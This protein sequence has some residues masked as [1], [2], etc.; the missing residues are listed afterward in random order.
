M[1]SSTIGDVHSSETADSCVCAGHSLMAGALDR[2]RA[3]TGNPPAHSPSGV[4]SRDHGT[5]GGGSGGNVA[6]GRLVASAPVHVAIPGSIAGNLDQQRHRAGRL[7]APQ[8]RQSRLV[9]GGQPT[10]LAGLRL[11]DRPSLQRDLKASSAMGDHPAAP[12]GSPPSTR[13]SANVAACFRLRSVR[14]F[15]GIDVLRWERRHASTVGSGP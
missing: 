13:S 8:R 4:R 3:A 15:L 7:R 6:T 11:R 14:L 9:L 5:D 12:G 2:R 1:Q 10:H